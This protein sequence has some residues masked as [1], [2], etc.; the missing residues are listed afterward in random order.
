MGYMAHHALIVYIPGYFIERGHSL[1]YPEIKMPDL[2][3]FREA[4]PESFRKLLVGPTQTA[5]NGD[6]VLAFLP[7]G[8]KEGWDTSD[9]GDA[10]RD[11]LAK[12][13]D[14]RY[15]DEESDYCSP[16]QV[17]EVRFGGDD[18]E[19]GYAIDPRKTRARR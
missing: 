5:A 14:I 16:F 4:M 12:M 10:I 6:Y 9:E 11:A 1:I 13:F 17:V 19:L 15:P 2:E 7:D 18:P 8:S 3:A